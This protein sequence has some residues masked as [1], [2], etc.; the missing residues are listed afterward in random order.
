MSDEPLTIEIP[1]A[2]GE[3]D[4]FG[5]VNNAVYLRYF[6]TARIAFFRAVEIPHRDVDDAAAPILAKTSCE[7]KAPLRYPDTVDVRTWVERIG[8]KSFTM[9]Y[10]IHSRAL[11]TLAATGDGVVVWFDYANNKTLELPADLRAR[12][13][14]HGHPG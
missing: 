7:F 10:E 14:Q 6:E 11:G 2:W 4:A 13:E 12:L 8:T 1:V 3:M 5:H 9:R